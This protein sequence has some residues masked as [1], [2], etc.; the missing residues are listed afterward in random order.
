MFELYETCC[1]H[2]FKW[3]EP[4]WLSHL[5][6]KSRLKVHNHEYSYVVPIKNVPQ[7]EWLILPLET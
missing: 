1:F 4:L 6:A 2:W 3:T 5:L 7:L